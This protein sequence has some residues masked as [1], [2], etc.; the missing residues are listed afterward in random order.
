ML[1]IAVGILTKHTPEPTDVRKRQTMPGARP[2]QQPG[3]EHIPT[4]LPSTP[5]QAHASCTIK[6]RL[7]LPV[8]SS[9]RDRTG[10]ALAH[11]ENIAPTATAA[12]VLS[13]VGLTATLDARAG[14]RAAGRLAAAE[15]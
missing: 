3:G 13:F 14:R 10:R 11:Q 7:V 15:P 5:R 9:S 4:A 1:Y 12:A 8:T 2:F 6:A